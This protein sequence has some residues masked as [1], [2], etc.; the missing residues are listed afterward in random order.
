MPNKLG[1]SCVMAS[2]QN[3]GARKDHK[4]SGRLASLFLNHSGIASEVTG[5]RYPPPSS[6][7]N[8]IPAMSDLA[9]QGKSL[10]VG[11]PK[12][13]AT[14]TPD[15]ARNSHPGLMAS[16]EDERYRYLL[17]HGNLK[18]VEDEDKILYAE[19]PQI[20]GVLVVYRKPSERN[21]NPERLNL[22]RRELT[23][24]PLLEGEE[25]LRLL[26][27]QHNSI[28]KIENLVSLPNLIF[29]DLYSNNIREISGL[30]TVPTLRVLMLGK[31]HI[32]L[33]KNLQ[34]LVKLDVL[35]LHSNQIAVI[36]NLGHLRELRV[37]NLANNQINTVENLE[38]LVSLTEL[39]LRRNR[40]ET[41]LG[42]ES[43]VKLQRLFLSN[44]RLL[45]MEKIGS[46][47]RCP[48]LTE[49]ALDGNPLSTLKTYFSAIIAICG[50]IKMID[51]KKVTKE[52]K[53][54]A[55][56]S[57]QPAISLPIEEPKKSSEGAF[58]TEEQIATIQAEWKAE[59]SR[60]KAK[61]INSFKLRRE[62]DGESLLKSGHAELEGETQL[63]LYGNSLEVLEKPDFRATASQITFKYIRFD[64]IVQQI[65]N[66]K[67][68]SNLQRLVFS[69]NNIH[70]FAHLAKL[71]QIPALSA[72]SLENNDVC[73]TV[74]CRSF[75]VYRFPNLKEI[76]G[77]EVTDSDR[78]K[79]KQQ[80]QIFDQVLSTPSVLLA[81]PQ[82]ETREVEKQNRVKMR[83]N[84]DFAAG[85][86]EDLLKKSIEMER[87]R[88]E[89]SRFWDA[90]GL[91]VTQKTTKELQ[92]DN[93]ISEQTISAE[94]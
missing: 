48:Q 56:V 10:S 77:L 40:I 36:E 73:Y 65:P 27:F 44:N 23:R 81:K 85:F 32:D 66:I 2:V 88:V 7:P 31:N 94:F 59:I 43:L 34:V 26:N 49:L 25:K 52:L 62:M 75:V 24:L 68:Y 64:Q 1:N 11:K 6:A 57:P 30:H 78:T 79:A 61:S 51:T 12:P 70:S 38:G 15:I 29:L 53:D 92:G 84:A 90:L 63:F 4:P 14:K 5:K 74:L 8:P 87:K 18:K 16:E 17:K 20:P 80:F 42:V 33:I 28:Q 37:L 83:K 58:S 41:I 89:L 55:K 93:V 19:L 22:D 69:E 91:A 60:L 86:V 54:Q 21:A 45:D 9:P 50:Q 46:L 47:S 82:G 39:N 35:D 67:R 72:L 76:S 71:E 3:P 13:I